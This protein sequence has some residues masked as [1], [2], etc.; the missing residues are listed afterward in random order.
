ME[1]DLTIIDLGNDQRFRRQ[2]CARCTCGHLTPVVHSTKDNDDEMTA[3]QREALRLRLGLG[4][5]V[6]NLKTT[7]KHYE[8]MEA[9]PACT[10]PERTQWSKLAEETRQRIEQT[11]VDNTLGQGDLFDLSEE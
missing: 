2:L 7:L 3:H 6:P 1:H 9:H 8:M 10:I 11:T 5:R 4:V